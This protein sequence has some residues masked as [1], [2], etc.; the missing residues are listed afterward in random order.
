[1]ELGAFKWAHC[2]KTTSVNTTSEHTTSLELTLS[3]AAVPLHS[4]WVYFAI[5]T[6]SHYIIPYIMS[7]NSDVQTSAI[8]LLKFL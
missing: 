3:V 8:N 4:E 2:V 1:M 5:M 6:C 7:P